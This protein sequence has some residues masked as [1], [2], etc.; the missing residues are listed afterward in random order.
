MT[1]AW[2]VTS[3]VTPHSLCTAIAVNNFAMSS[4]LVLTGCRLVAPGIARAA[5]R[6][7]V[8]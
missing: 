7:L 3:L 6:I 1:H 4:A 2:S 8:Y 5:L